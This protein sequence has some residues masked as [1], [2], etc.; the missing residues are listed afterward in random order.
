M[1]FVTSIWPN[2]VNSQSLFTVIIVVRFKAH[3]SHFVYAFKQT[4][5][6]VLRVLVRVFYFLFLVNYQF[7]HYFYFFKLLSSQILLGYNHLLGGHFWAM[8]KYNLLGGQNNLLGGSHPVDMLFTS[9]PLC[10]ST[11][12]VFL[13]IYCV[14]KYND[15]QSWWY[16]MCDFNFNM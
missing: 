7:M 5:I 4:W 2:L 12:S 1:K 14:M 8:G 6:S 13:E 9:L 3:R 16:V 11:C 10:H 15:N